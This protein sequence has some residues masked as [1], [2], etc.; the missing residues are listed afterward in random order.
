MLGV[1]QMKMI[2]GVG[3]GEEA[4]IGELLRYH[5]GARLASR[6]ARIALIE[7]EECDFDLL[8]EVSQE[9]LGFVCLGEYDKDIADMAEELRLV[10]LF[11]EEEG[12]LRE[13]INEKAILLPRKS[14][15]LIAPDVFA[16][17]A[18]EE[19][20]FAENELVREK[21]RASQRKAKNE[22]LFARGK[23][24]KKKIKKYSENT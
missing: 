23:K 11:S 14:K 6:R 17:R 22:S 1:T 8:F 18:F 3:I 5:R 21:D 15:A 2:K 19:D 7:A 12:K 4:V 13:A 24:E 9:F 16:L 20:A 10:G